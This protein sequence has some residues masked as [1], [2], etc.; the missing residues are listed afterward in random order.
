MTNQNIIDLDTTTLVITSGNQN[1]NGTKT[2][3]N[4]TLITELQNPFVSKSPVSDY[5]STSTIMSS[6]FVAGA[7][8]SSPSSNIILTVPTAS[9]IE[10][11][12]TATQINSGFWVQIVNLSVLYTVTILANTNMSLS[13]SYTTGGN[14]IIPGGGVANSS[15]IFRVVKISNTPSYVLLG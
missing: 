11:V 6:D 9:N 7:I 10:A 8:S 1:I 14:V 4:P 2:F 15:R 13:A 12:T 3:L 5:S